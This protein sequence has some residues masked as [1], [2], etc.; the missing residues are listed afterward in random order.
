MVIDELTEYRVV[1]RAVKW[2]GAR[3]GSGFDYWLGKR[4]EGSPQPLLQGKA[5]LE[6][7]GIRNGSETE[8]AARVR[9]K[10]A[11]TQQSDSLRIDAYVAVVEFGA[12][13]S[14]V[15]KR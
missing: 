6:V 8:I 2:V 4:D 11:Q 13:R 5:R 15:T 14:R 12:P 1:E 10:E 3:R 9:Q 7:S